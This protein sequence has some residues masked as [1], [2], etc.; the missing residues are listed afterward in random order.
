M[1][2]VIKVH[3]VCRF[4]EIQPQWSYLLRQEMTSRNLKNYRRK[5]PSLRTFAVVGDC[6]LGSNGPNI[7]NS[8]YILSW[9][10]TFAPHAVLKVLS[11]NEYSSHICSVFFKGNMF[12]ID[13]LQVEVIT[14]LA[15]WN[16]VRP[17]LKRHFKMKHPNM[18]GKLLYLLIKPKIIS[19]W[20]FRMYFPS[21]YKLLAQSYCKQHTNNYVLE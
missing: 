2:N 20:N 8:F 13:C 6:R 14:G 11:W 4:S 17:A 16:F 21:Q 7:C 9:I 10:N 15:M 12:D 3:I 5:T 19:S 1:V 18:E